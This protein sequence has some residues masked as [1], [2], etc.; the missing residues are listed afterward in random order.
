MPRLLRRAADVTHCDP[1]I[2]SDAPQWTD[3]FIM[4]LDNIVSAPCWVISAFLYNVNIDFASN[5]IK[6]FLVQSKPQQ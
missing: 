6:Y 2:Y 4:L 3:G 5:N 1:I